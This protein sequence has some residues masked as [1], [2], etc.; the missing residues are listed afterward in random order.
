MTANYWLNAVR[1]GSREER[2]ALLAYT[3]EREVMT[4]PIWRLMTELPM[5]RHCRHDGLET[6]RWLEERIVNLP[7]SVP[8]G[9]LA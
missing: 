5:Y 7:S 6:S 1:L 4:R 2:D 8:D 9:W 3:N